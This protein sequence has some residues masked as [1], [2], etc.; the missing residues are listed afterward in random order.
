M[1]PPACL[2]AYLS[3][4]VRRYALGLFSRGAAR[5]EVMPAEGGKVLRM[6]PRVHGESY[7]P[8][9]T[10]TVIEAGKMKEANMRLVEEFGSQ[11]GGGF[12][13]G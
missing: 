12:V 7:E 4:C 9:G 11:V 13:D 10:T 8:R 3:A 2:P 5:L 6:E 1:P